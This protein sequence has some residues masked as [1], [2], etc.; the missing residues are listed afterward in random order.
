MRRES[1]K[2][3]AWHL[4]GQKATC[5]AEKA[6]WSAETGAIIIKG[7]CCYGLISVAVV[8]MD[9]RRRGGNKASD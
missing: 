6:G 4:A 7:S 9:K 1:S 2:S 5:T 3:A 8:E